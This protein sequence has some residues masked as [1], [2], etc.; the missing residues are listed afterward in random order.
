MH[1]SRV[2]QATIE[3]KFEQLNQPPYSPDLAPSDDNLF[4]L[5]RN[6]ISGDDE[7]KAAKGDHTDNSY[8]KGTNCLKEKWSECSEVFG[9]ILKKII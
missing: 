2:A 1:K 9:G 3:C 5:A 6:E 4:P 7:F 8:F